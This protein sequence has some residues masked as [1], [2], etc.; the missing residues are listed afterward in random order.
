MNP[1]VRDAALR[2]KLGNLAHRVE[3]CIEQGRV[4]ARLT[5]V[6]DPAEYRPLEPQVSEDELRRREL[7]GEKRYTTAEVL[8]HLDKQSRGHVR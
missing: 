7:S 1:V 8:A 3:L 4:L 6:S 2:K 5:P